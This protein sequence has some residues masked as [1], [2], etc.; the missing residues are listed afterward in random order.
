[1]RLILDLAIYLFASFV[2]GVS[3]LFRRKK[4]KD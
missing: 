2:E 4:R 1:M 3:E